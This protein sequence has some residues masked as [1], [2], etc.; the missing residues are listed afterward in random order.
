MYV[1]E[2]SSNRVQVA[3]HIL[4]WQ[5]TQASGVCP[6]ECYPQFTGGSRANGVSDRLHR[7]VI[8]QLAD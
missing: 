3:E 5:P 2:Q 1:Q 8:E 4:T 7:V 6:R